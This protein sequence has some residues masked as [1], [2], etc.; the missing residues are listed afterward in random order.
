MNNFLNL[1]THPKHVSGLLLTV[2]ICG[3]LRVDLIDQVVSDHA[4]ITFKS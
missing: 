3:M 1:I 2:T 4:L